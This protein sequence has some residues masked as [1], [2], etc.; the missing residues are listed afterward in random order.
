MPKQ[1]LVIDDTELHLTILKKIA[2]QSGF[3]TTGAT[4]VRAA[5]DL[6]RQRRFDC[7]TLDLSLGEESGLEILKI[8]AEIRSSTPVIII[9]GSDDTFRDETMRAGQSL[10][11][12][13]FPPIP[14]PINLAALRYSLGAIVRDTAGRAE[15]VA[16]GAW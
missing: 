4:S 3:E 9:S 16:P 12:N 14:K 6:L 11:L 2:A 8:L 7:I 10:N 1:L 5:G 13:M 15:R